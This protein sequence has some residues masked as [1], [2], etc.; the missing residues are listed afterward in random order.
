MDL[1]PKQHHCLGL[2]AGE[3]PVLAILIRD[4]ICLEAF[5]TPFRI[6]GVL[7]GPGFALGYPPLPAEY[8][9]APPVRW[10]KRLHH[11]LRISVRSNKATASGMKPTPAIAMLPKEQ[12]SGPQ[13]PKDPKTLLNLTQRSD[14]SCRCAGF[15]IYLLSRPTERDQ[16]LH[17]CFRKFM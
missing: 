17:L 12:K 9:H 2:Q 3:I 16:T 6:E 11:R 5:E 14:W 10:L 1:S 8:C 4:A 13:H 15:V 7:V